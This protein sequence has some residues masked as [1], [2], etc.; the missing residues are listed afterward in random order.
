MKISDLLKLVRINQWIKN[1]FIF[2]PLIF[3]GKLSDPHDLAAVSFIFII[4][5]LLSSSVYILNDLV[6]LDNDK[7]HPK[8]RLRP[9]ARGAIKKAP[10]VIILAALLIASLVLSYRAGASIFVIT[11]LY[12]ITHLAYNIALKNAVILDVISIAIGFELRVWAGA[13]AIN[14]LPSAWLQL[15]IFLLALLL[16]FTKRKGEKRLLDT[17]AAEHRDVLAHYSASFLDQMITISS[18]LCVMAYS[19]YV[20][21]GEMASKFSHPY[22]LYTIPFVI[23]GISRYLYLADSKKMDG[24][25]EEVF[26]AD[27]P[28][29]LNSVLWLCSVIFILYRLK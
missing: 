24:D 29:I 14:L 11:L 3:S 18:A 4:F 2:M 8:K 15:C 17:R 6:G 9:L 25:P 10:A 12:L 7:V 26:A 1:G 20:L 27:G 19:L 21:T 16:S 13:M 28:F 23:Y 22:M 5:C